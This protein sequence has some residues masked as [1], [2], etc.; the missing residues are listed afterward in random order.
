MHNSNPD[1]VK[2][3]IRQLSTLGCTGLVISAGT[4]RTIFYWNDNSGTD[5]PYVQTEALTRGG[6]DANLRDL[7][8]STF[9]EKTVRVGWP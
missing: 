1:E 2:A 6:L 4:N 3:V 7:R 9:Y 8:K 5:E